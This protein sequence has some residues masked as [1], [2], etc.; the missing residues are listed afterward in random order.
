M[1]L[2]DI[3]TMEERYQDEW[4]QSAG[5]TEYY[6]TLAWN[7]PNREHKRKDKMKGLGT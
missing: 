7:I 2:K 5:I 4:D 3:T 1:K 6:R